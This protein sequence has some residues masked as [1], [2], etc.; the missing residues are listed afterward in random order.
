MSSHNG[1]VMSEISVNSLRGTGSGTKPKP[2][3]KAE[4]PE[5][6]KL[7]SA[8]TSALEAAIA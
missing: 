7:R 2:R 4:V 1:Y 8:T 5:V 6:G 3:M